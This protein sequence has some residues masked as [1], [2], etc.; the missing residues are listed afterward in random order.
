MSLGTS[1]PPASVQGRTMQAAR[2]H[3]WGPPD[4]IAMERLALPTPAEASVPGI[5]WCA[6]AGAGWGRPCR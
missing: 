2:V 5:R 3:Q 1:V 6:P 4:V